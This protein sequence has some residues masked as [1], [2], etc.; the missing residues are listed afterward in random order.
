M[1]QELLLFLSH[2]HS[3]A[4]YPQ[5]DD[6]EEALREQGC[7]IDTV[8]NASD[9]LFC[10]GFLS[11]RTAEEIIELFVSLKEQQVR[12][13]WFHLWL[14]PEEIDLQ[15]VLMDRYESEE[16]TVVRT[17]VP[18]QIGQKIVLEYHYLIWE[19][20]LGMRRAEDRVELY[21]HTRERICSY[22]EQA[23]W[24]VKALQLEQN[25]QIGEH[26]LMLY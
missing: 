13:C 3:L 12:S 5:L 1:V 15:Q 21:V 26:W 23:G 19:Q 9:R 4:V 24:S 2:E 22:A 8:P 6:L 10:F 18:Q 7:W 20:G 16:V 17:A 25:E 14:E 11:A